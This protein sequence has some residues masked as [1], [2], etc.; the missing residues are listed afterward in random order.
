[1]TSH[2]FDD[3]EFFLRDKIVLSSDLHYAAISVWLAFAL[4]I[5]QFDFSPRLAIWSPEKRCGKSTLLD[6]IH[7]LLPHSI[8]TSNIS[9]SALYRTIEKDERLTML[10]DESETLF[11]RF[12][13]KEKAEA[14]RGIGNAGFKR[15]PLVYRSD[16]NN[17]EPKGF[18]VF[19]PV[20]LA[21]IGTEAIPETMADRSIVIE[22]RRKLHYEKVSEYES[23]QIEDI[24]GGVRTRLT[25]WVNGNKHLFRGSTPQ[26]PFEL[27]ARA[28][29]LWKPL[30]KIAEHIDEPWRQ[31]ISS[32]AIYL[33]T[34]PD[35]PNDI[36]LQLRLLTDC[37]EVFAAS[38]G[39]AIPTRELISKLSALEESPWGSMPGFNAS[40]LAK[41]LRNYGIHSHRWSN[42]RGYTKI[43]FEDAWHRYLSSATTF[44]SLT[45]TPK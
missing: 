38:T 19:C 18:K 26:M 41:L 40:L 16:G 5:D 7:N 34:Q 13:D 9:A 27:N 15:G 20:V 4:A 29:D 6:V 31:K 24:F 30:F 10:I 44:Q 3:L 39:D 12:A 11:G 21:G 22:M 42:Y 32:A 23:D 35:D 36:S 17:F 8:L 1:M 28:R 2:P 37:H 45:S 33:S 25:A 43:S 14:L